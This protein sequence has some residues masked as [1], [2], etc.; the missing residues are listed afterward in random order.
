M[1]SVEGSSGDGRG[2]RPDQAALLREWKRLSRAATFVAVLTAPMFFVFLVARNDWPV[3]TSLIVPFLAV[4]AFRGLMDMVAHRLIP[5]PSLYGADREA[6]L[7]DA[8]ARRR[9][10]FWRGKYRLLLWLVVLVVGVLGS[11]ALITGKSIPDL[12]SDIWDGLTNPQILITLVYMGIQLPLLFFINFA[13]LFGPLLF[14]GLKQMK[15]YEPGDADWGVRLE[16]V[17]GQ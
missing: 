13:I 7:D 16:D 12:V 2:M 4:I 11:I 3:G 8:T 17:R 10:W 15:G 1:A 5:R 9:L 14:F 6:L